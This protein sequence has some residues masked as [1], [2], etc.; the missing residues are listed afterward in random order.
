MKVKPLRKEEVGCR[1]SARA[2]LNLA[3]SAMRCA[4]RSGELSL[5]EPNCEARVKA[6]GVKRSEYG[7]ERRD[8]HAYDFSRR[9]LTFLMCLHASP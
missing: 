7:F 5:D 2:T 4:M 9:S 1:Q 3:T 6:G 8:V